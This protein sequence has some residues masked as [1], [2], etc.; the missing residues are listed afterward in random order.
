MK[1]N[2]PVTQ[3]EKIVPYGA[4]LASKTDLEGRI[5]YA[6]RDFS[7]ICGFTE[8]ELL[9]SPH[10]IVRHPDVP[11]LVFA[12]LW[13][14]LEAGRPWNG[15][16]KN[17]T[18]NGDHY[19]VD[20]HVTPLSEDGQVV[21]YLSVRRGATREQIRAAEALYAGVASGKIVL[22]RQGLLERLNP[23]PHLRLWQ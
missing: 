12:N 3:I 2:H 17:R 14:T 5:T 11:A 19:W 6:N 4:V 7:E 16:V 20:A 22:G 8:Q 9:G 21:G 18:K 1:L 13:Q 15:T 23:L 10:N